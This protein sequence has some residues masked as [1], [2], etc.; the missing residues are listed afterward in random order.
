MRLKGATLAKN[1][2]RARWLGGG[3]T[4]AWSRHKDERLVFRK[5]PSTLGIGLVRDPSGG[6]MLL[7]FKERLTHQTTTLR[8]PTPGGVQ[9][10]AVLR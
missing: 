9:C 7:P 3:Q 8:E 2:T 10:Q 1:A 6:L 5:I 4:K